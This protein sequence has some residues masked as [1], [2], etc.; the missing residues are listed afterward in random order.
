MTGGIGKAFSD[1]SSKITIRE[2][3]SQKVKMKITTFKLVDWEAVDKI[4]NNY[5]QQFCSW[6]TNHVSKLFG[7][8]TILYSWVFVTDA[9]C[10]R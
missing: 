8:K 9:L 3:L 4:M 5:P 1:K 10:S 6:V 7:T 2:I